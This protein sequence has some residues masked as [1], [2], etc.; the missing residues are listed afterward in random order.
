M[1]K[2]IIGGTHSGC[3]KTTITC[4]VLSALKA[5]GMR[6]AAFKCG[7]DYIDPMF[8]K[9]VIGTESYNLDSFFCDD[10]TL[11]YLLCKNSAN[12]DISVIEGVMGYYDGAVG[13]RGAAHSVSMV[14]DTPAVVVIDCKG[15]SESIGAFMKGFLEYQLPNRIS[16]FIFNRLPKRLVGFVKEKC[17]E[18]GVRYFGSFPQNQWCIESRRLGLVTAAEI[19]DIKMKLSELGK[20][21][22]DNI[23]LDDIIEASETRLPEFAVKE[24]Q[25]SFSGDPP[26]I[27]VADDK[28]FCFT[29]SDNIDLLKQLGCE[30]EYFSPLNDEKLPENCCG[31][32]LSGGYPEL[33]AEKLSENR[34]MCEAV[35]NAVLS[36]M[37]TIAECGG[38]MYLHEK[39]IDSDGSEYPLAGIVRGKV[40]STEKLQ[41]FGYVTMTATK[42]NILCSCG[43]EFKAHEFHYWDS[44]DCGESF[45]AR[46]ADGREWKCGH[47]DNTLYAGF[48]HLYFYSDI[49]IAERF[50]RACAGFGERNGKNKTDKNNG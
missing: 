44:S 39:L 33:Y 50:V 13:G 29:Y 40:F 49:N 42:D 11:R 46:K 41:R 45:I 3:G 19:S 1:R 47:A 23:F 4:A 21:A 31:M 6:I 36:G 34:K 5:R 16:G 38:F 12:A 7:P 28:A 30:I 27:A 2:I 14:T 48:P 37:P 15:M 32:I 24:I 22:E 10:D 20:L 26:K 8:H 17:D 9:T 43:G 25:R 35:K 18:F